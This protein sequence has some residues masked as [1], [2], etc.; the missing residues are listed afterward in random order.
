MKLGWLKFTAAC[1]LLFV[2][3]GLAQPI[4]IDLDTIRLD[5]PNALPTSQDTI[6]FERYPFEDFSL[7]FVGGGAR[8]EGMGKAYLAASDDVNAISWNPAAL[9]VHE[10]PIISLSWGSLNPR[11]S[12]AGLSMDPGM[13]LAG[14]GHGYTAGV[15]YGGAISAITAAAFASPLRIKGHQFVGSLGYTRNF[16]EHQEWGFAFEGLDSITV[17]VDDYVETFEVGRFWSDQTRMEGGLYTAS[18]G[19]GTR[20]YENY[21][22]GFSINVYSGETV[23]DDYIRVFTDGYPFAGSGQPDARRDTT[24]QDSIVTIIDSAKFSGVNFTIGF[25]HHGERLDAGLTIK[26][27]FSLK[28]QRTVD[29]FTVTYERTKPGVF[30]PNN[31]KGDTTFLVNKLTKYEIPIRIGAGVSY[32]LEDNWLVALDLEYQGFSTANVLYRYNITIDPGGENEES[33]YVFDPANWQD[34]FT[35]RA[36]TEYMLATDIG[37]IPLRAGIGY[38]PIP[39]PS[40]QLTDDGNSE[41]ST[42]TMT[43]FSLGTGIHWEQ[44]HLDWA[45]SFSRY[46]R[47]IVR[48]NI[49]EREN[50]HVAELK[51]RN[52]HFNVTFTG[53]F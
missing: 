38:I 14:K 2:A 19:F 45:Y 4:Q 23:R 51:N 30:H 28:A 35:A 32:R 44:I 7:D 40:Q 47:D 37:T 31:D 41:Y 39:A 29:F 49:F 22:F 36:G 18:F 25:K 13:L 48:Y 17:P 42:T 6:I 24:Q 26:T 3:T 50:W 27:P 15:D 52:H 43:R 20:I 34:V 16:D 11:G 1:F 5:V 21:S 12:A 8:A 33:F 10:K 46:N 9:Y 53:V